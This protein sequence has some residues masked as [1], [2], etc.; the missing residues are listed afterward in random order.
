ML[1]AQSL[2]AMHVLLA[3]ILAIV[4]HDDSHRTTERLTGTT[5]Y[6]RGLRC[7]RVSHCCPMFEG[8]N[9]Y[10]RPVTTLPWAILMAGVRS[11][12]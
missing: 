9:R 7:T 6:H 5:G 11:S 4:E 1:A 8:G 10:D 3:L 12:K 2:W